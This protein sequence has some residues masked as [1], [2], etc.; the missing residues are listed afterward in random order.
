MFGEYLRTPGYT[1][2]SVSKALPWK[3]FTPDFSFTAYRC[4]CS[5]PDQDSEQNGMLAQK[6]NWAAR[7]SL[8]SI[9]WPSLHRLWENLSPFIVMRLKSWPRSSLD[10]SWIWFT[11]FCPSS[12]K[13]TLRCGPWS[14]AL[15]PHHVVFTSKPVSVRKG[16]ETLRFLEYHWTQITLP[17]GSKHLQISTK[18]S[19]IKQTN[20]KTYFWNN[21]LLSAIGSNEM[22]VAPMIL[23][24]RHSQEMVH[25]VR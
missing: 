10:S 15:I 25:G 17:R 13:F 5:L 23:E 18:Q 6:K 22:W 2:N 14:L 19:K 7:K 12:L 21:P 24:D 20:K 11:A 3:T 1:Q 16:K 8:Y 4:V 9:S